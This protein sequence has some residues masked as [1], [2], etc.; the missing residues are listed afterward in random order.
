[1]YLGSTHVRERLAG[2]LDEIYAGACDKTKAAID[3]W[4][5][6]YEDGSANR[7][8]TDELIAVLESAPENAN[9]PLIKKVLDEKEFLAKKS[10][11]IFGGDGWAYDCLLYTSRC[12]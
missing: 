7:V 2:Y 9:T 3:A 4:R 11:W 6:T 12:V 8:A 5:A 10:V 1:M